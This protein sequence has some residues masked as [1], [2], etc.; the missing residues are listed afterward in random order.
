MSNLQIKSNTLEKAANHL[1]TANFHS[2]VAHSAY[3][4]CVQ[5]MKHIWL[6]SMNKTEDDLKN[7]RIQFNKNAFH[8]GQK[9]L[10][11][12]E[13]LIRNVG[14]FIRKSPHKDAVNDFRLFCSN[15]W[16]LKDLRT[17][18]DYSDKQFSNTDSL[19]SL[20]LSNKIMPILKKY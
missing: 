12:H 13:F 6:Y 5:L 16:Q 20:T 19:D 2:A 10:G 15:I 17:N 4:C 1:H 9:T 11:S 18:A 7:E 3:Y 8:F 14:D